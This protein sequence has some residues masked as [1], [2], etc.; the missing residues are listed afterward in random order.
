MANFNKIL[1]LFSTILLP[2]INAFSLNPNTPAPVVDDRRS[3]LSKA[4]VSTAAI[5]TVNPLVATASTTTSDNLVEELRTSVKKIETIP[6]LLDQGEWDKVRTILKTPP[7]NK[8]WNLGE[9]SIFCTY[10]FQIFR[11]KN[12]FFPFDISFLY[13]CASTIYSYKNRVKIHW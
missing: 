6:E 3:F 1:Y 9:V 8:L 13:Y 11:K 5:M 10:I 4:F 12:R 7:V 2:S